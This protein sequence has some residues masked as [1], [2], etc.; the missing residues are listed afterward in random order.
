MLQ[1][2]S[3]LV[4]LIACI[5]ISALLVTSCGN[6][7]KVNSD[8]GRWYTSAQVQRGNLLFQA[9]CAVCHGGQA[10]G[11]AEDWRIRDSAGNFPPPPLNGTAHTWH[12]PLAVLD[13]V[14][15]SGGIPYGGTMPGF[16]EQLDR[17]ERLEV[18]A[19]F[20][21]LWSDDIYQSWLQ[22]DAQQ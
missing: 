21:S 22:I 3:N 11:L 12:H 14:I 17:K 6:E 8:T 19:Y 9:N 10:Q 4:T 15:A 5:M 16:G 18:I 2:R 13:Q 7:R 20:Q 1:W